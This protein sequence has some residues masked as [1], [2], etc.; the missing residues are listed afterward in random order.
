MG[1]ESVGMKL[2]FGII[3]SQPY[4]EIVVKTQARLQYFFLTRIF[5]QLD[6]LEKENMK[7]NLGKM[8]DKVVKNLILE[9]I[10]L[11]IPIRVKMI[12]PVLVIS[13][14]TGLCSVQ[15]KSISICCWVMLYKFRLELSES[16]KI[17]VKN[18]FIFEWKIFWVQSI[19]QKKTIKNKQ[20]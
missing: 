6:I 16:N 19:S 7:W 9:C 20:K 4:F 2:G 11:A 14:G 13:M 15:I 8:V 12:L 18:G 5:L 17:G 10:S 3:V 1:L